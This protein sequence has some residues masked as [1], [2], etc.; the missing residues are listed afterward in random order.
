MAMIRKFGAPMESS[1]SKVTLQNQG[2]ESKLLNVTETHD[3]P[4]KEENS[5][6]KCHQNRLTRI[7]SS[8]SAIY[9]RYLI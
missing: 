7:C 4:T 6:Q 1:A 5:L 9:K 3:D 2:T 8:Q